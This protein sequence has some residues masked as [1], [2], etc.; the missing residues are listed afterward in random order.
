M[1]KALLL[2]LFSPLYQGAASAQETWSLQDCINHA[3]THN[4]QIRKNQMP[5]WA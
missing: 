4:I 3:L 1:K 5:S 2:L